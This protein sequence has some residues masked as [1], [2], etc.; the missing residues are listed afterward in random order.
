MYYSLMLKYLNT[1]K[2]IKQVEI[3]LNFQKI[4]NLKR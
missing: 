4:K 2:S 3:F 1:Y